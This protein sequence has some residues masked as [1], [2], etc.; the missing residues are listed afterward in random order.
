MKASE[1][2]READG[3]ARAALSRYRV[4]VEVAAHGEGVWW[5]IYG[6]ADEAWQQGFEAGWD[7]ARLLEGVNR[8]DRTLTPEE[9]TRVQE[10]TGSVRAG[11]GASFP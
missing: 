3:A 2:E 1:I 7:A 11:H 10:L 9:D 5:R 6:L 8:W 4:L